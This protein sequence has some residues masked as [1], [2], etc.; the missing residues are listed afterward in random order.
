MQERSLGAGSEAGREVSVSPLVRKYLVYYPVV[1]ARGELV[2]QYLKRLSRT[3]WATSSTI[4]TIQEFKLKRLVAYTGRHVPYYRRRLAHFELCGLGDLPRVPTLTKD[5][6]RHH[7]QDLRSDRPFLHLTKKTTAG[8]TGKAVT[9]YKSARAM[10]WELAAAWRGYAWAGVGMGDRQG[11]FWGVPF[12]SRDRLKAKCIDIVTNRTRFSAFAFDEKRLHDYTRILNRIR[13]KYFYGY[14]SMLVQY[15]QHLV[16]N[17]QCLCFPLK[18]V[19]STSEVLTPPHRA[20]LQEVFQ[21]PV[22]DEYGCAE[23]GTVA[24]ECEEGS[25]H[26]NAENMIVE[27][28]DGDR[29]CRPGEIGELV[30]TELNNLAMPLIRY[31]MGDY[32]ALSAKQC[33]CGRALPVIE[34]VVGRAY[35]IIRNKEGRLFHGEFFMYIF[36]EVKK[37]KMGVDAFQVVQMGVDRLRIRVKP[38]KGYCAQTEALIKKRILSDYGKDTILE[39]EKVNEIRREPSGKMRLV[40]GTVSRC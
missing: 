38:S 19:I 13:P 40:V 20:F 12:S 24:H 31:R 21:C 28:L 8:S 15:A 34:K 10:G 17:N 26:V 37:R 36:E 9:V 16:A 33:I 32:A 6:L 22:Y 14:L 4:R 30:I 7:S 3:Q 25:M 27:V 18:C 5:D 1:Y 23:V 2:P 39:F 35:D 29:R 11:R